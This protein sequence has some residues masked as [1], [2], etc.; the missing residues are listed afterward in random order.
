MS[1]PF[2]YVKLSNCAE[3]SWDCQNV[4]KTI[5]N[6]K[7]FFE[8]T[9]MNNSTVE[10]FQMAEQNASSFD[11]DQRQNVG[12]SY[13][14]KSVLSINNLSNKPMSNVEKSFR[15]MQWVYSCTPNAEKRPNT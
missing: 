7:K 1:N 4:S 15:I 8:T 2:A 9:A 5:P 13:L 10:N 11:T 12:Y 6:E 14:N 3:F